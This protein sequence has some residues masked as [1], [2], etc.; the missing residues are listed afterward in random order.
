MPQ[1]FEMR[2]RIP[3]PGL[4]A[5]QTAWALLAL[6]DIGIRLRAAG[7]CAGVLGPEDVLLE[8][9]G[10]RR[11]PAPG[12]LHER[13]LMRRRRR[14]AGLGHSLGCHLFGIPE[15]VAERLIRAWAD[16]R[17][18][19]FCLALVDEVVEE[20]RSTGVGPHRG[21]S[22]DGARA[23]IRH[24]VESRITPVPPSVPPSREPIRRERGPGEH[25][26]PP[27]LSRTQM[28]RF[29]SNRPSSRRFFTWVRKR[30]ASAP[31]TIR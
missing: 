11:A 6:L 17:A 19:S 12:G 31:S 7:W 8:A 30:A 1:T 13:T 21:W 25:A 28:P 29:A 3:Q 10:V 27:Q 24:A 16:P 20:L 26:R 23:A 22:G 2:R 4:S 9:R 15:C 18:E 14:H 5:G